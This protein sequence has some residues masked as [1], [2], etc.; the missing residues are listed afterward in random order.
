M[1]QFLILMIFGCIIYS[2]K[3][4]K[5]IKPNVL[6]TD[7]DGVPDSTD[8]CPTVF[9]IASNQGCP[10]IDDQDK[11]GVADEDDNCKTKANPDQKDTDGDGIGDACDDFQDSDGDGVEDQK[12]N[13]K[14]E[15][16]VKEN[17]GCPWSSLNLGKIQFPS[18]K[19]SCIRLPI[20][21]Q[22]TATTGGSS[23]KEYR[24]RL[25]NLT[26]TDAQEV[27][28]AYTTSLVL[29]IK[30][31]HIK[32]GEIYQLGIEVKDALANKTADYSSIR[33][34]V[35]GEPVAKNAVP[36]AEF[37]NP[38]K[39]GGVAST[40]LEWANVED[41][42]YSVYINQE[43]KAKDLSTRK[44]VHNLAKGTYT[45]EIKSI[46]SKGNYSKTAPYTFLVE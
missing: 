20:E 36:V 28:S 30:N 1:K 14:D 37:L 4:K 25:K 9:G 40:E 16:G 46:D 39:S 19:Q 17:N 3:E 23:K 10:N 45:V 38:I 35:R 29:P 2:C 13:C 27:T 33:F 31:A 8:K 41:L 5:S 15:K 7:K 42:K 22:L 43:E 18:D 21:I 34:H 44:F 12:D 6:D 32:K 11:D 24:Y 26:N